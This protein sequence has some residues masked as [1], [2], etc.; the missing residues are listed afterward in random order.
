[1]FFHQPWFYKRGRES[2]RRLRFCND[3]PILLT[4]L[5]QIVSSDNSSS[6]IWKV[7]STFYFFSSNIKSLYYILSKAFAI[8]LLTLFRGTSVRNFIVNASYTNSLKFMKQNSEMM[9]ESI[10]ESD[11]NSLYII[12]YK[13]NLKKESILVFMLKNAKFVMKV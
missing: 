5:Q 13:G 6:T 12:R 4:V 11:A 8:S 7:S 2:R 9:F 10:K 1:M 3:R